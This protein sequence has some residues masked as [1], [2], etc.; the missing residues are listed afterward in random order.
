MSE[1]LKFVLA[2]V[3]MIVGKG[4]N[5]VFK[6]LLPLRVVKSWDFVVKG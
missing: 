3:E 5:A 6:R 1:K 4:G 2:M